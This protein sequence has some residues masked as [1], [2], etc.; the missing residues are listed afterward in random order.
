[1]THLRKKNTWP[2]EL[3]LRS[4]VTS[5]Y[6]VSGRFARN[7]W[8][9]TS[10]TYFPNLAVVRWR[11]GE[12]RAEAGAGAGAS[13]RQRRGLRARSLQPR[14]NIPRDRCLPVFVTILMQYSTLLRP[15]NAVIHYNKFNRCAVIFI[16]FLPYRFYHV[17]YPRPL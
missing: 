8:S 16:I 3:N 12:S 4:Y 11:G 13:R 6:V 5:T 10:S 2:G 7:S 15:C 14:A 1:M 17:L 9:D